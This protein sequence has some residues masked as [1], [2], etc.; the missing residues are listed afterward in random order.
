LNAL[1]A[2]LFEAEKARRT[3]DPLSELVPGLTLA[4]AYAIQ[5]RCVRLRQEHDGAA[6]VGA[7]VGCTSEAMQRYFGID[8]PDFGVLLS[9]M[10]VLESDALDLGE[11][12]QP[13]VEPEIAFILGTD[14]AG[15]GVSLTDALRASAAVAPAIEI[16]DSRIHAWRIRF[17]DT[18]ADNGSSARFVVGRG[19]P[20]GDV[21][22]LS[23]L[24]LAFRRNDEAA[25]TATGSAVLG[26]PANA[27]AWLA[28]TLGSL[29]GGLHE[30]DIV[31][32][33]SLTAAFDCAPADRFV[34]SFDGL[35]VVQLTTRPVP[36]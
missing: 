18:V 19:V 21:G 22:D 6:I 9:D 7:K 28:N 5:S 14:L 25:I 1:A 12:I 8:Q 34:A 32:S 11:L 3:I 13:K 27:V 33:G 30:G 10:E 16:I 17:E 4:D 29:G 2:E 15:P 26:H 20:P 23:S 36:A 35:D 31:L 24:Q